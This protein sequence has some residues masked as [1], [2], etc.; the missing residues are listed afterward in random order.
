ME[1]NLHSS[2]DADEVAR[3]EALAETWWD[4][5]GPFRP[6]HRLNPTR[7]QF[8]RD[9]AVAHFDR[10]AD[11]V[12]PLEGL[13]AVDIGCGGG[14]ISEPLARMGAAVTGIDPSEKNIG[15]ARAHALH[16]DAGVDYRATTAGELAATGARFDLVLNL[17]VVEHVPDVDAF[18]ADSAL[19]LQPSGLMV[20]ATLN[21]TLKSLALA[22]IGAEYV[23]RWLPRGTHDWRRFL[24]PA[25]LAGSI[26][27]A[28]LAVTGLQGVG[29][30]PL[31]D[32]W[33]LTA[34][35]AVNY[36]MVAVRPSA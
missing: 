12:R 33:H 21:R 15:I 13:S 10:P 11:T 30:A 35:T 9:R 14:L 8:V 36:M 20:C 19:L 3:F 7:L 27:R 32:A 24:T 22:K 28:G 5:T 6:L 26:R 25:E 29:Y 23:L 1:N 2:V 4:P 31:R 16:S 34:D 18:I 17:E